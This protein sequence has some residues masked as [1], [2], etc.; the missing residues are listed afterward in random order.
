MNIVDPLARQ[1][2]EGAA[3]LF[4]GAGVSSCA[5]DA[6]GKNPPTSKQLAALLADRF[7]SGRYKDEGLAIVGDYAI[8]ETGLF[9]VQSY[10]REIF[11]PYGPIDAHN[12][13]SQLKWHGLVTTNYD[14]LVEQAYSN[15]GKNA[16]QAPAALI[17]NSDHM[18]DRT[19]KANAM[20]YLKLHGCVTRI[21][22]D[23]CPL[24]LSTEQYLS[25]R[26][27]REN[28][29]KI[30]KEWAAE[31]TIVFVGYSL[32][33][34][35]IRQILYELDDLRDA[36]QRHYIVSR[37]CDETKRS[38]WATRKFTLLK[39]TF[40]EFIRDANAMCSSPFTA[41]VQPVDHLHP[42]LDT[43]SGQNPSLSTNCSQ[44]LDQDVEYVKGCTSKEL[45]APRDFYR[46]Y[47][48]GWSAI[49]QRL[50]VNRAITDRLLENHFILSDSEDRGLEFIV[51]KGHA[52]SGK[53]ILLRRLAWEAANTWD[54]L[55]L[56]VRDGASIDTA[57]IDEIMASTNKRL[58]LF[59]DDL[60]TRTGEIVLLLSKLGSKRA[61]ATIVGAERTNEWNMYCERLVNLVTHT[62][63][64]H[65][66]SESEVIAL[67]ALLEKHR[68][69]GVL[70]RVSQEKRIQAFVQ[71]AGRQLLV[72]L[73]EATLGRPLEEIIE[74][75]YR[76]I[77]PEKAQQVYLTICVLNR[78]RVKVRAGLISRLHDIPFEAF[79]KRLFAPL[80]HIV[81]DTVDRK[82]GEMV[83]ETRH[84]HIAQIVYERILSDGQ[85]RFQRYV[86]CLD[87]LI[88]A[89]Q[90]D[91]KA[92][93]QM[94]RAKILLDE[95]PNYDDARFIH[96][97]ADAIAPDDPVV[98]H[99][100]GL[101]EMK[102]PNG[103][104]SE[105]SRFLGQAA[106]LSHNDTAIRHTVAELH[107]RQAAAAKS[108]LERDLHIKKAGE[109]AKALVRG[110]PESA[111]GYHTLIKALLLRM[112]A[113]ID[114]DQLDQAAFES[115]ILEI[116][117][118][119]RSAIQQFPTNSHLLETESRI[120]TIL[121]DSDRAL[122]ALNKAFEANP[123]V[124]FI[125]LRLSQQYLKSNEPDKAESILR[126]ALDANPH[127][128]ALHFSFAKSLIET[129]D[130]Q[131]EEIEYHLKRSFDLRDRNYLAQI[132]YGRQLFINGKVEECRNFFRDNRA[133][134]Y[135][136]DL[137]RTLQFPFADTFSGEIIQRESSYCF[138]RSDNRGEHIY[139]HCSNIDEDTWR[140]LSFGVRVQ[141]R[142]AFTLGGPSAFNISVS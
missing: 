103:S 57:A 80:E 110:Q 100:K 24:I 78:L 74:D 87:G 97:S 125:A 46:G 6:N 21:D 2:R 114:G 19:R 25:Y 17:D 29:F 68:S 9:E 7:L 98:W 83:Y 106:K 96:E 89:F 52:G 43:F 70:E 55:C 123:R 12:A 115:H 50:D 73:H 4:L 81:F 136:P 40:E 72:V 138:I 135:N 23:N 48:S 90:S 122:R 94:I 84:P 133:T 37:D 39:G 36:R 111:H 42:I 8:S 126:A 130:S 14:L 20:P 22:N 119:L 140:Q 93:H 127:D 69:L 107:L 109:G 120:A 26:K 142:V 112:E 28:L 10:I 41:L 54:C 101:Y 35:N 62:Q 18:E 61:R 13:I 117:K 131:G 132:L 121:S 45:I 129:G 139:G 15:A 134:G 86:F 63:A 141:Y 88:T 30:F 16:L 128:K 11:E 58:F 5:V 59:V 47:N 99:Q 33:D 104:L 53:S 76:N 92:F 32:S 34:S 118:N 75:E 1:I 113:Q 105:A 51:L 91:R 44:F 27:G 108:P 137:V 67:I 102:R 77:L 85:Q 95:F 71:R 65:P 116:E 124:S 49:E 38:Y 56:Y 82:T 60:G 31:K 64:V 66:L 3:V 79:K